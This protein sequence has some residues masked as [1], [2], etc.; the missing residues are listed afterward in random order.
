M[1]WDQA[2]LQVQGD[3]QRE[4]SGFCQVWWSVVNPILLNL[5]LAAANCHETSLDARF[6]DQRFTTSQNRLR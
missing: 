4:S 5:N 2:K 3:P 1:G 6:K